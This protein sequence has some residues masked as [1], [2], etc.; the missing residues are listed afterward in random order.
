MQSVLVSII[1]PV[2][3][4]ELYISSL[5]EQILSNPY[6]NV[7]LI[8]GNDG[9]KDRT[10]EL[11]NQY[12]E[13]PK[14]K[15]FNSNQNI[16]AGALRNHLLKMANG[17]YIAMQDADDS[18]DESRFM[19]QVEFLNQNPEID[20]VGT[21]AS[22][23]DKGETWGEISVP[24]QP[25]F[26]NWFKQNSL[27]HASIMFRKNVL[28]SNVLYGNNMRFG[29]DYYFLTGLFLRGYN[30]ANLNERLY[31][32]HISRSEL[33]SRAKK[34]FFELLDSKIKIAKL[35]PFYLRPFF[36]GYHFMKQLAGLILSL[37]RL[38]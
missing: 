25:T 14:I 26:L 15:V 21:L 1:I 6:K 17:D 35:F 20:V 33:K 34:Y 22:L 31:A 2:H 10:L 18:F 9:S 13:N 27:V 24:S 30:V 8:I 12:Y 36:I 19:K 7:E 11:L 4:G 5:I 37:L 3:N 38:K 23:V 29:E 16:G 32:Y 28:L